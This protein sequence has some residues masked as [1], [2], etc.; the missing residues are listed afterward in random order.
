MAVLDDGGAVGVDEVVAGGLDV[1]LELT[2]VD[3]GALEED[4]RHLVEPLLPR[5]EVDIAGAG[6]EG[7]L[8]VLLDG[9]GR[10]TGS[11]VLVVGAGE[12]LRARL[13]VLRDGY[14]IAAQGLVPDSLTKGGKRET[15]NGHGLALHIALAGLGT[16][17]LVDILIVVELG[18]ADADLRGDHALTGGRRGGGTQGAADRRRADVGEAQAHEI[19]GHGALAQLAEVVGKLGTEHLHDGVAVGGLRHREQAA[20]EA[21]QEEQFSHRDVQGCLLSIS[22]N[23]SRFERYCLAILSEPRTAFSK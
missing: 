8:V 15:L 18:T 21:Q 10:E 4:G 23:R 2:V 11:L 7:C 19:G 20:A 12:H 22:L 9:S 14:L 1:E 16:T 17:A 3:V 5:L 6:V 13:L